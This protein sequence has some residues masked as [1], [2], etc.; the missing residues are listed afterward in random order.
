MLDANSAAVEGEPGTQTVVI[1]YPTREAA[2]AAY[3]SEAY[4]AVVGMR[5]RATAN[6]RA[7]VVDG[8]GQ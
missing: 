1:E 2:E 5:H 3:N 8:F 4:Q 6:G 7:V